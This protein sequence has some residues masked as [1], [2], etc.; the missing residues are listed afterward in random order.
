MIIEGMAVVYEGER[1]RQY[2]LKYPQIMQP[3]GL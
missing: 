2:T 3:H 1:R